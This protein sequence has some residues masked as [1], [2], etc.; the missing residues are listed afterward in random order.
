MK[1]RGVGGRDGVRSVR[2][3]LVEEAWFLFDSVSS[4]F[5][6][7]DDGPFVS[8]LLE[9]RSRTGAV[10]SKVA[11]K[12]KNIRVAW[13]LWAKMASRPKAR[14]HIKSARSSL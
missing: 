3:C 6:S 12:S 14:E 5:Q 2:N 9:L 1:R 7:R 10:T 4:R 8:W 11:E 13:C